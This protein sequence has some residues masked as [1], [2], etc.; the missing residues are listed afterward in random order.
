MPISSRDVYIPQHCDIYATLIDAQ[1]VNY[2]VL[3][4]TIFCIHKIKC[5]LVYTVNYFKVLL[6]IVMVSPHH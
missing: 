2:N 4:R 5:L 3:Y 1:H 6:N